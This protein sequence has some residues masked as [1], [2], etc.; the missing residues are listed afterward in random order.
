LLTPDG[1]PVSLSDFEGDV[2][3]INIFATW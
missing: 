2:I 1:D 3:L